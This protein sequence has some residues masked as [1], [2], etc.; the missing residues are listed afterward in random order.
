MTKNNENSHYRA[1]G[2]ILWF[3][4]TMMPNDSSQ[5]YFIK[6]LRL[7]RPSIAE[8]FSSVGE[9]DRKRGR[10]P[11]ELSSYFKMEMPFIFKRT[12]VFR[13]YKTLLDRLSL[14]HVSHV[15]RP[16][17]FI[18]LVHVQSQLEVSWMKPHSVLN[19]Q[20]FVTQLQCLVEAAQ[21]IVSC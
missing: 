21:T 18:S 6:G 3:K 4:K 15:H 10:F 11:V 12:F 1:K 9:G 19:L 5:D 7:V 17:N 8:S 13:Q 14:R 2:D 16:H 20:C